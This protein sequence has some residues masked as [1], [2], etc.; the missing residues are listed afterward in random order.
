[1]LKMPDYIGDA[2]RNEVPGDPKAVHYQDHEAAVVS[3]LGGDYYVSYLKF[4]GAANSP[5]VT[6]TT[7]RRYNYRDDGLKA[8]LRFRELEGDL[9]EEPSARP[10]SGPRF[11][12]V[13]EIPRWKEVED[14]LF[15]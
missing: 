3:E 2:I 9:P 1:M 12:S 5:E 7:T 10:G 6:A 11:H 4:E 14:F 8:G 15:S 13:E